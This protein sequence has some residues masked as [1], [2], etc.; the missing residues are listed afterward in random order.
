MPTRLDALAQKNLSRRALV[1]GA[2]AALAVPAILR[3]PRA[4]SAAVNLDFVV[5]NYAEDIIQANIDLFQQIYPDVTVKL[6]SFT[7]QTFHETMVNRFR[8]KTSTDVSYN[9]GNWLEE[10]AA[11]GW[12]VPLEDHFS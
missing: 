6:S 7:W 12:V 3:A 11:A 8:S 10:F 9:G 1:G 5:W 4:A 2:T